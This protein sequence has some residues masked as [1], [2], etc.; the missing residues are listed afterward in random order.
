MAKFRV[1]YPFQ[2]QVD[3]RTREELFRNWQEIEAQ[4][5]HSIVNNTVDAMVDPSL[6]ADLP[7]EAR[8]KTVGRALRG[9]RP[10]AGWVPGQTITLGLLGTS[11]LYPTEDANISTSDV[12]TNLIIVGIS[13]PAS[14]SVAAVPVGWEF[15]T[16]NI[17]MTNS[18]VVLK[19]VRLVHYTTAGS[20]PFSTFFNGMG[21][22]WLYDSGAF[23]AG[24]LLALAATTGSF[25]SLH[26]RGGSFINVSHRFDVDSLDCDWTFPAGTSITV[27]GR[28]TAHVTIVG[29]V[30]T[31]QGN[32]TYTIIGRNVTIAGAR[33]ADGQYGVSASSTLVVNA[34]NYG[35]VH[36]SGDA[37]GGGTL[38]TQGSVG[39][40][41]FASAG[42][43]KHSGGAA[44]IT[45]SV[46]TLIL[47]G[48]AAVSVAASCQA[49]TLQGVL[50]G[51]ISG[52]AIACTSL[53]D[54]A[55]VLGPVGAGSPPAASS[56]TLDASSNRNVIVCSQTAFA[57]FT[58]NGSG[59]RFIKSTGAIGPGVD[60]T[61]LHTGDAAGGDLTGTYP[62]PTLAASG[63]TPGSYG[64]AISWPSI[65][66]DAKGRLTVAGKVYLPPIEKIDATIDPDVGAS[67]PSQLIFK[68][69][70]EAL[71][72]IKP[73]GGWIAGHVYTLLMKAG[74]NPVIE[75]TATAAAD[76]PQILRI[77][78]PAPC[79][80]LNSADGGS[81]PPASA[82]A[83]WTLGGLGFDGAGAGPSGLG[84]AIYLENIHLYHLGAVPGSNS[85]FTNMSFVSVK[86]GGVTNYTAAPGTAMQLATGYF[87]PPASTVKETFLYRIT[88]LGKLV[89]ENTDWNVNAADVNPI[90]YDSLVTASTG[91]I[92]RFNGGTISLQGSSQ[93]AQ[94]KVARCAVTAVNFSCASLPG[95]T[96]GGTISWTSYDNNEILSIEASGGMGAP[97]GM[98][99]TMPHLNLRGAFGSLTSSVSAGFGYYSLDVSCQ[100]INFPASG[101]SVINATCNGNARLGGYWSGSITAKQLLGVS[102]LSSKLDVSLYSVLSPAVSLDA[103]STKNIIDAAGASA[104]ATPV[105]DLGTGNLIRTT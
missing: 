62:N 55:L 75:T 8:Y 87:F 93:S 104:A 79:S 5:Y 101:F 44:S 29:G 96:F 18:N 76:L 73:G 81:T 57:S 77:F 83:R 37:S 61:A 92:A 85:F 15:A 27:L 24:G 41:T 102:L 84:V 80:V 35:V 58:D 7:Q 14:S 38:N 89:W 20:R 6:T 53:I 23:S 95:Y 11:T 103:G 69:V 100:N 70:H 10:G 40:V 42:I 46:T 13:I 30:L 52:K 43:F 56:L 68:T 47:Q 2:D 9:L 1:P 22:L 39:A 64:D 45:A 65:T 28:S 94:M 4:F 12:P 59:N 74:T 90:I 82:G 60:S 26:A 21:E 78:N 86:G 105:S 16:F 88:L 63:V 97:V 34:S 17:D 66:T 19:N 72:A 25:C 50:S 98:T 49:A 91:G 3:A 31:C 32:N 51:L 71:V 33:Y 67:I 54:S 48:T 99:F 36:M